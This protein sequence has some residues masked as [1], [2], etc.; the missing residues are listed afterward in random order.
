[1]FFVL[2]SAAVA[3]TNKSEHGLVRVFLEVIIW[4]IKSRYYLS[5]ELLL[6]ETIVIQ[7]D[8]CFYLFGNASSTVYKTVPICWDGSCN[9]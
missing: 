8:P 2:C 3:A 4:S 1:M 6:I 5:F 9:A 7:N